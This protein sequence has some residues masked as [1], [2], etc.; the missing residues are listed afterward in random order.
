MTFLRPDMTE[1]SGIGRHEI[2]EPAAQG[3]FSRNGAKRLFRNFL[4]VSVAGAALLA[5]LLIT[6]PLSAKA[7][8]ASVETARRRAASLEPGINIWRWFRRPI[9][10][11]NDHN[12]NYISDNE[13]ITLRKWGYRSIRLAVG[14]QF[15]F[16]NGTL[17][18]TPDPAALTLLREAITRINNAGLV[19]VVDY[20]PSQAT[21]SALERSLQ[22]QSVYVAMWGN[23]AKALADTD[24]EQVLLEPYNEPHFRRF[25]MMW[26]VLA[27]RVAAA[28]R[29]SA[30]RHTIVLDTSLAAS[31]E[32][33]EAQRVLA[34]GNIIYSVHYYEPRLFVTQGTKNGKTGLAGLGWPK[35]GEPCSQSAASTAT[36]D[37]V[38]VA[39]C[40]KDQGKA[41]DADVARLA[42]WSRD[43]DR[44]LW[45]GEYG[46]SAK[47]TDPVS[48]VAWLRAATDAFRHQELPATLWSYDDCWGLALRATCR[49]PLWEGPSRITD[50]DF[51]CWTL[52]AVG[53]DVRT[54]PTDVARLERRDV[55][56]PAP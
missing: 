20:H 5:C 11:S 12:A 28:I 10:T 42:R 32:R 36:P 9:A 56:P 54:C 15:L 38:M 52:A 37:P 26:N 39:Y 23:L 50:T 27:E 51:T 3:W 24:P 30:P 13:L 4:V 25:P 21:K 14:E 7:D 6:M 18:E 55:A 46:V 34:D 49:L 29:A 31:P 44:A 33:L 47:G 53:R 8:P 2:G 41:L 40:T 35:G 48:R 16:S 45:I 19:V 1:G 22:L 43:H 17:G